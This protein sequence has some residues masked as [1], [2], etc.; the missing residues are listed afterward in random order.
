MK[1]LLLAAALSMAAEVAAAQAI[2][3]DPTLTPSAVRSTNVDEICSAG[4]RQFR[5]PGHATAVFAAYGIPL[6]SRF[7]F[8]LD[9]LIPLGIGGADTD[10]NLWPEPTR[11]L[12]PV[13]NAEAK[14]VLEWRLRALVCGGSLPVEEAQKAIA[15]DWTAA[16][17]RFVGTLP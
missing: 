12:E 14:D 10:Q 11:A 13:W 7:E 6:A 9:H 17:Q 15:E 2:V 4:T 1:L 3:P 16:Y 5:S 8:E